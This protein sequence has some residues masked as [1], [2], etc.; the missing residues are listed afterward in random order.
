MQWL[1]IVFPPPSNVEKRNTHIIAHII[2]LFIKQVI[3]F[4]MTETD[5]CHDYMTNN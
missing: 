3:F 2:A 4:Y 5:D 1:Y